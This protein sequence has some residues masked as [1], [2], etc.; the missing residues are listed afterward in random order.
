MKNDFLNLIIAVAN[1]TNAINPINT[2]S[3]NINDELSEKLKLFINSFS[4]Y[5]KNELLTYYDIV[6]ELSKSHSLRNL[7]IYKFTESTLLGKRYNFTSR[8]ISDSDLNNANKLKQIS[9]RL[10]QLLT[11]KAN[12]YE[13]ESNKKYRDGELTLGAGNAGAAFLGAFLWFAPWI[14]AIAAISVNAAGGTLISESK[15]LKDK[16]SRLNNKVSDINKSFSNLGNNFAI[17]TG[18]QTISLEYMTDLEKNEYKTTL[19]K[20]INNCMLILQQLDGIAI[21]IND[22]NVKYQIN[23]GKTIIYKLKNSIVN[24]INSIKPKVV[25]SSYPNTNIDNYDEG[26]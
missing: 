12:E 14:A 10:T 25:P 3:M 20:I 13:A 4:E 11:N 26:Y 15:D 18:I 23:Q 21:E 17:V 6:D 2:K 22:S 9:E 1:T 16:A 24:E 5:E 8:A 7:W 19:E